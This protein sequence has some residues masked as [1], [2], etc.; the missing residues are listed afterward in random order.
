MTVIRS[1]TALYASLKFL[2]EGT[3]IIIYTDDS[4]SARTNVV[5]EL[6]KEPDNGGHHDWQIIRRP[7]SADASLLRPSYPEDPEIISNRALAD[8]LEQNP[9]L[10]VSVDD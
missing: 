5:A 4:G 3:R 10:W 9:A 7:S 2:A 1:N 8:T 6:R